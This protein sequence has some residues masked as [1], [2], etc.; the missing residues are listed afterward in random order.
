MSINRCVVR[1]LSPLTVPL[2]QHVLLYGSPG[3]GECRGRH[4]KSR[5]N[6]GPAAAISTFCGP[7]Q[8]Q[9]VPSASQSPALPLLRCAVRWCPGAKVRIGV[10]SGL[11]IKKL[12]LPRRM[13]PPAGRGIKIWSTTTYR[14]RRVDLICG[15]MHCM[16]A[17]HGCRHRP[18]GGSGAR[19][20]SSSGTTG[21]RRLHL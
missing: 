9:Y 19:C 12:L 6:T 21:I 11:S 16:H 4:Q 10:P 18:T 5:L 14:G 15:Y 17:L 2:E 3:V 8:Q 20:S 13:Y 7:Q 1:H